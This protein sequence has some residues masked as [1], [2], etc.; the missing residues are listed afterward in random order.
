MVTCEPLPPTFD[1]L[2]RNIAEHRRWAQ[3]RQ[4]QA[5]AI[6]QQQQQQ[7]EMQS[8]SGGES[9]GAN[10]AAAACPATIVALCAG[11]GD[12]TASSA[13]FTLYPRAAGW[14]S[15]R[16][17][18][19][20]DMQASMAAFLDNALASPAAAAA[21]GLDPRAAAAGRWLRAA[22]PAWA[23]AAV[24]RAAVDLMLGGAQRHTCPL[25]S[26][27]QLVRGSTDGGAPAGRGPGA[28]SE[29][30]AAGLELAGR[31]IDLLKASSPCT[32]AACP[33]A[34]E[35]GWVDSGRRRRCMR[36]GMC[37]PAAPCLSAAKQMHGL[38]HAPHGCG[39]DT[40][41]SWPP[42]APGR[43]RAR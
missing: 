20:E 34:R 41:H 39:A 38:Q 1:C 16:P 26:V 37:A 11:V 6:A 31:G 5:Q 10:T 19:A 36:A 35:L 13:E 43:C 3:R 18:P 27:R 33:A 23:F 21:A 22:A 25:L 28:I 2:R 30:A 15:L 42:C 9:G 29:Q 4:G 8:R 14:S 32:A 12:G 7:Q 24:R 17:A 40:W